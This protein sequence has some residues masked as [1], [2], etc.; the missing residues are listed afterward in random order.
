MDSKSNTY[1]LAKYDVSGIQQYIFATNRLRENVGA[2]F[3]VTR[4]LEEYLPEAIKAATAPQQENITESINVLDWKIQD[5]LRIF[6]DANIEAEIIYIGG[7]NAMVLFRDRE[8]FQKV[9]QNLGEKVARGCQGIYLAVAYVNS[10][11]N[12]FKN[13]VNELAKKM[14]ENKANMIRQ[15]IYSPFPVVEQDNSN[16]QPITRCLRH[17]NEEVENTGNMQA[18]ENMTE[19]RYQKWMAYR[20]SRA[21]KN[22][23]L[24]PQIAGIADY[25]YPVDM[26]SLCREPGNDSYIAVVH[27][28]GN[29]MGRQI[30][31]VLGEQDA[32]E[33]AVPLLRKKSKE[34]SGIFRNTYKAVLMR[35]WE[36]KELL[37]T[38]SKGDIIFP[39]RPIV[40]DGDD[41]TFLC[42]ADLAIP[43]A[44]GFLKK[45]SVSQKE[46]IQ[47]ITACAGIAFVHSHFPFYEAYRI[48]EETCSRAKGKWY[49]EKKGKKGSPDKSFLDFRV[50]KGSEAG[51]T[52]KHGQ[53]HMRP[54]SVDTEDQGIELDSLVR[55]YETIKKMEEEWPSNRLHK[56]YRAIL[57]GEGQ[58]DLLDR[59]F[60]SRGY[61]MKE[62]MQTE[63]WKDSPLYDALELRGLCK[64]ELL[65]DFLG[66]QEK[67]VNEKMESENYFEK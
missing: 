43:I 12:S 15:P 44:A 35:L 40:L 54:Y 7:G 58:L 32:Y 21:S 38:D 18:V 42:T 34:I 48:A 49:E 46:K 29:G 55:L 53:W 57:S 50:L 66:L 17:K 6:K 36:H 10:K 51:G 25:D 67:Q 27:I 59:E 39:L 60:T 22:K 2:S 26:D 20:C 23:N 3:Q 61:S 9:S 64:V 19:M 45:L 13:D 24:Y 65:A 63:K 28:D 31:E 8:V 41:F 56:I 11:L 1:I 30:Q 14:A 47:K 52:L 33:K 62:L 37:R 4:I 5:E 16:H